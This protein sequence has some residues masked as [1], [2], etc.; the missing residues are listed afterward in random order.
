MAVQVCQPAKSILVV[1]SPDTPPVMLSRWPRERIY[2]LNRL[3]ICAVVTLAFGSYFWTPIGPWQTTF[4]ILGRAWLIFVGS[5][6]AHEATHLHLGAT[7]RA[8]IWWGRLSVVPST[9]PSISV[10]KTHLVHHA[11]TNIPEKDPDRF[12]K[13]EHWWEIPFR[14]LGLPHYWFAWLVRNGHVK[15]GDWIELA[16]TYTVYLALYT[17]IGW[18]VGPTRLAIGLFPAL[19]LNSVFLWYLFAVKTHDGYSIG[20]QEE[21]SHNYYGRFVFWISMGLSMHRVHHIYPRLAWIE[22]LP[23]VQRSPGGF[24]SRFKMP[25]DIVRLS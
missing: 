17:G 16:L 9:V 22:I 12:L 2:L 18:A 21:R 23:L 7:R 4:D 11:N 6:M 10:R 15:R 5:T 3:I 20:T 24:W 25:R 14:C 19:A 8:N 13:P 1:V